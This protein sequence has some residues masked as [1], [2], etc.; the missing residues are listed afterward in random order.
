MGAEIGGE[1]VCGCDQR[2]R[3]VTY[4]FLYGKHR[5]PVTHM[6]D[7]DGEDT[8]DPT[9]ACRLVARLPNDEWLAADCEPHK[10]VCDGL[11]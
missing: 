9:L 5:L 6:F 3:K 10:I 11:N 7:I 2:H 4:T 1:N 8:D